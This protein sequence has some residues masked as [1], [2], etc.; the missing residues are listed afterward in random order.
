MEAKTKLTRK[1]IYVYITPEEWAA[2]KSISQRTG[3]K[4]FVLNT[5]MLQDFL[6]RNIDKKARLI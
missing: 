1:N 2:Y 3:L 4:M 5:Q 6:K